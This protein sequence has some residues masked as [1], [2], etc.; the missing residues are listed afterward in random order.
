MKIKRILS[1]LSIILLTCSALWA[2]L[3]FYQEDLDFKL[4]ENFFKVAGDYYFRNVGDHNIKVTLFYPIPRDSLLGDYDSASVTGPSQQTNSPITV[5]K[6]NGFFFN[7]EVGVDTIA[8]YHVAYRQSLLGNK[9]K[10]I[11]TTTNTWGKPLEKADFQLK[12]PKTLKIYSLSMLPD[13]LQEC[14]DTYT[15]FWE[16]KN[17]MPEED[18]VVYYH[19][20]KHE[21]ISILSSG[22]FMDR[23]HFLYLR[24][25]PFLIPG[26]AVGFTHRIR[27]I[28]ETTIDFTIAAHYHYWQNS[29]ESYG[30]SLITEHF[31]N[32]QA[33]GF[34]YRT[35][36]GAEYA[37]MQSPF[38]D[39]P[40]PE[41][42]WIPNVTM[43]LGYSFII[44]N[45]SYLRLSAEIGFTML[46]GRIN[47]EFLF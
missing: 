20:E 23:N 18:F 32:S 19:K 4:T 12:F 24:L 46:I 22:R 43:G 31:G 28:D 14:N 35:N 34:F 27:L 9:A 26:G 6:E 30:L 39:D 47:C 29:H 17:F 36:V 11:F 21:K 25:T 16:R 33:K 42:K 15:L 8:C 13:S 41:K 7:V 1:A 38:D 44:F 37:E 5:I 10:Y 3:E 45:N 2:Q 40:E